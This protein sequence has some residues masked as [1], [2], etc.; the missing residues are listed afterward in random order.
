[1]THMDDDE[2]L[3]RQY[4]RIQRDFDL[5][6]AINEHGVHNPTCSHM[7]DYLDRWIESVYGDERA[8]MQ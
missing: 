7:F 3:R 2:Q 4:E 5:F 8:F 1:M 6:T